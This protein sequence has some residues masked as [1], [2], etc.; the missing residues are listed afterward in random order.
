MS[1]FLDGDFSYPR[2]IEGSGTRVF[3]Q[4]NTNDF[5]VTRLYVQA[6][7][8]YVPLAISTADYQYKNAYLVEESESKRDAAFVWFRRIYATVPT[9]RVESRE[10][11]FTFPG[12]AGLKLGNGKVIGWSKYGAASPVSVYRAATVTI[13]YSLGQPGTQNPTTISY[14]GQPVDFTGVV[15][16][17]DGK[18]VLGTTSPISSPSHFVLS[19][20]AR[21][22]R[23]NIWEK[24]TVSISA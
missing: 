10:T 8:A 19:D 2:E 22:W 5:I 18:T 23:G 17:D 12:S 4:F 7:N 3:S 20:V 24:E 1:A 14:N 9:S 6:K 15:Y 13:T 21:R 11:L 16:T